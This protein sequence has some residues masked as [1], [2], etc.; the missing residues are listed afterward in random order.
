[1]SNREPNIPP[2]DQERILSMARVWHFFRP[3]A[4]ALCVM[5]ATIG[6]TMSVWNHIERSWFSPMDASDQSTIAFQV[7]SGE[8][9][10]KV[11]E[12]LSESGLIHNAT[13]FKYYADFLG[14][15]QKIQSG[16]YSL[17]RSMPM[18]EIANQLTL[19]DGNPL[20]RNITVIPGWTVEKIAD[21]LK[22]IGQI[23]SAE[24]FLREC[25][26]GENYTAYYYISD[27]ARTSG[28][29]YLL[30]GYLM[31]DTY[32]V[33]TSATSAD[34]IRK[35]LSQTE[36]VFTDSDHA[37]ADEIGMT[38][39]EVLTLASMI[40]KEA[41]E[42]DFKKVSAVFHNRL[43]IGMTLGSDATVKYASGVTRL[44]LNGTDLSFQSPYNTYLFKGLPPGPICS[45]SKD[46]I[47]AALY[48]D[49][50]FVSE[51]YLYFC[52]K[53]PSSGELAFAKTLEEHERNVSI[54][55]PLW[56]AYDLEQSNSNP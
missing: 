23:E 15:S 26:T 18:T 33:Y 31:P 1:M 19:G 4:I 54:Y 37:R 56:Q 40:E 46:A 28:R 39:D 48:P 27:I 16:D 14:Y 10:T 35:L 32:E 41:K 47:Q 6:I 3:L 49:E 9:L 55:S 21:Y 30:E 13:V 34:I 24:D 22:Q 17:S 53:E 38:M 42:A 43:S 44:S 5:L 2:H 52:T 50:S 7:K 8:S 45:P 36:A 51:N 29:K 20:V 25:R 11:A 12:H